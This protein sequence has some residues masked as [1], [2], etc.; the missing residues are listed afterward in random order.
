MNGEV[1]DLTAG[2]PMA[3]FY[4]ELWSGLIFGV[5]FG[6]LLQRGHIVRYDKQIAMLQLRDMTVLKY[7]LSAALVGM[8]GMFTLQE[9]F[10]TTWLI[11][12]VFIMAFVL[13]G[14]VFG[15]GWGICGYCPGTLLG[16]LGEG[17][18]DALWPLLGGIAGSVVYANLVHQHIV[19]FIYGVA[20]YPDGIDLHTALGVN[21]WVVIAVFGVVCIALFW[22][23]EKRGL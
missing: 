9:V 7:M 1:L 11:R 10:I 14:I 21:H 13:G 18:W 2:A 17:R 4:S 6:F 19:D 3:N 15:I 16:A 5:L 20:A 23:L 8:I 12:P 22:W